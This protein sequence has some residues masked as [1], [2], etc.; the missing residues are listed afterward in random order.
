M[1]IE[2]IAW[3]VESP[4]ETAAW[5]V[6]HLG[7]R[8][9]RHLPEKAEMH[10]LADDSGTVCIEIYRNTKVQTPDYRRQHPL[11]LHLALVSENPDTDRQRLEA[12]GASFVEEERMEDGTHIVMMRD[13]WGVSLQ[14]C[15]RAHPFIPVVL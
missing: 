13:P 2:H 8:V 1:K 14:L 3:D 7:F 4:R 15:K 6:R 5:Y 12:A 11:I 10:F 9:V